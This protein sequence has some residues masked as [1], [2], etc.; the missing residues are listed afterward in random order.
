[1]GEKA[2]HPF[3]GNQFTS[4]KGGGKG[5]GGRVDK[6]DPKVHAQRMAKAADYK[7]LRAGKDVWT[8]HG[9]PTGHMEKLVKKGLATRM[10]SHGD[11]G[12]FAAKGIGAKKSTQA[13]EVRAEW[14]KI[15]SKVESKKAQGRGTPERNKKAAEL[16][17]ERAVRD[18]DAHPDWKAT[19]DSVIDD[20]RPALAKHGVKTTVKWQGDA[21]VVTMKGKGGTA[22]AAFDHRDRPDTVRDTLHAALK[23]QGVGIQSHDTGGDFYAFSV[24]TRK[25]IA[26]KVKAQRKLTRGK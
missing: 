13:P 4:S 26:S 24:G 5:G 20:L 10:S 17:A 25:S 18:S 21:V 6:S 12:Y 14:E 7:A 8:A 22:R 19:P 1:M 11:V 23:P 3:R 16:K 15:G 2:G 9:G